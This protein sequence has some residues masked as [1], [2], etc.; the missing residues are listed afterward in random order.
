ML[1]A[2]LHLLLPLLA[3]IPVAPAAPPPA[4]AAVAVAAPAA[5]Q[6]DLAVEVRDRKGA[7]QKPPA[8]ADLTVLENGEPRRV[9][10]FEPLGQTPWRFVVYVDRVLA[11]SR[12]LR[13]ALGALTAHSAELAA[14]G[15]VEVVLAEPE[16]L[17]LLPATRDPYAIEETLGR[18]AYT[19]LGL[20]G[21]RSVRRH[22]R[23]EAA[24]GAGGAAATAAASGGEAPVGVAEEAAAEEVRLV[25]RQVDNLAAWLATADAANAAHVANSANDADRPR[26]LFYVA[27]GWD[28]DP[29]EFYR[30]LRKAAAASGVG[31][32][33]PLAPF[34]LETDTPALARTVA[35]LGWTAL[36]IA[37]GDAPLPDLR[38]P[39]LGR[40]AQPSPRVGVTLPERDRDRELEKQIAEKNREAP[41]LLHPLEPLQEMAEASGGEVLESPLAL[42]DAIAR[43]RGRFLLRYES[44]PVT[45]GR[46]RTVVVRVAAPDLT[47]HTR[48]LAGAGTPAEVAALHARRLLEGEEGRGDLP[49]SAA[50]RI[51]DGGPTGRQAQVEVRLN[52]AALP[53]GSVPPGA[54]LRLTTAAPEEPLGAR[55]AERP[56]GAGDATGATG[57]EAWTYRVTV[58]LPEGADRLAVVVD[59]PANG[60]WGGELA[61]VVTGDEAAEAA[62][63]PPGLVPLPSGPE[64]VRLLQPGREPLAGRVKVAARVTGGEVARLL[65][66]L[67]G[68]EAATRKGA[69]W[70]AEV[71]LGRSS[72]PHTLEV[73]AYSAA[74][75]ELGRDSLRLN[76][77][78]ERPGGAHVR[79]LRPASGKAAG[80]VEVEAEVRVPAERR[81]ERVEFFWNEELAATLYQPPFHHRVLVPPGRSGYLRVAALL[82]DGMT[83]EDAVP[84]NTA[85]PSERVDVQLVQLFVVVTDRSGKPVKGLTRGDFRVREDGREQTLAGFDDAGE[86]PITVGLAVDTSASMFVK[87][88]GVVKAAQSLVTGGLTPRDSS[89]LVGFDEHP[90]LVMRPTRDRLAVSTALAALRPDGGTGLWGAVDFSLSQLQGVSGR[91]ALIVYSD[92]IEEEEDV[93]FATCLRRARDSGIPVYLIFTNA[94][95]AHEGR[96]LGRLY[97]GRLER[98]TAAAGGKL[99]FVEPDQDLAAVY[100]EILA[101]LRSQYVLTYYP[102]EGGGDAFREVKVDVKRSGLKARTISGYYP[103]P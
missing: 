52:P 58:P 98:L 20:D 35:A 90:R 43:L 75:A 77:P 94:A 3:Q 69:P 72:R 62:T 39:R 33:D 47:L 29:R 48:Q 30:P 23:D 37:V 76:R 86:F 66:R 70:E 82:D 49:V 97:T 16:P 92:G 21:V 89:L 25:R 24:A 96:L 34:T 61:A 5:R 1:P 63:P 18:L 38:H 100:A 51:A 84:M 71:N 19:G 93:S 28:R 55:V 45:D 60:Q 87:L 57:E 56:L 74:G 4:A 17:I 91:K 10:A 26:A 73:V 64:V 31:A 12:T 32:A 81:I 13:S 41:L 40:P 83:A 36:P 44:T 6:V 88:P 95:A 68:R 79:I 54:L 42:P 46:A 80:A 2:L 101:E 85:G 78:G 8:A 99:Y 103:E 67:D 15:T 65:F 27:D 59:L 14:L 50:L 7:L 9:L 102:R 11:S 53:A 22:L